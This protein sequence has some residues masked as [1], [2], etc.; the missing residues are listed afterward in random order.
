MQH[1]KSYPQ[2]RGRFCGYVDKIKQGIKKSMY[3][4]VCHKNKIKRRR[5]F[6]S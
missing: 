4:A 5:V 1:E 2:F 6:K 3:E